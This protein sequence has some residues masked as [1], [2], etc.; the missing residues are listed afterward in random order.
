MYIAGV[1]ANDPGNLV[2]WIMDPPGI[3]SATT[4]PDVG[5]TDARARDIAD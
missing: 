5:V 1:L 4:M 2:R 3:D